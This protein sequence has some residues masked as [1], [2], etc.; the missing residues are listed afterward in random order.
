MIPL[1]QPLPSLT[2]TRKKRFS[3]KLEDIIKDAVNVKKIIYKKDNRKF[4]YYG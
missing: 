3:K 4:I 2:Y 1:K